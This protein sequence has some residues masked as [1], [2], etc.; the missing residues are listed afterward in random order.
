M[1]GLRL[2]KAG[3]TSNEPTEQ[4]IWLM[5]ANRYVENQKNSQ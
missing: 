4:L 5:A 1:P 3:T 2:V